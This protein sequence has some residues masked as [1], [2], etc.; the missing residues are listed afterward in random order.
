[1]NRRL[2]CRS[3]WAK[4]VAPI[5][6]AAALP[7]LVL[8]GDSY[9]LQSQCQKGDLRR[10]TAKIQVDGIL[11][12]SMDPKV[13]SLPLKVRGR[14]AYDELRLDAP[15]DGPSRRSLRYYREAQ[16]A[17]R[18]DKQTSGSTLRDDVR[19]ITARAESKGKVAISSPR[20]PLTREELELI[21]LQFGSLIAD[22][23]LPQSKVKIGD[24]WKIPNEALAGLSGL[25]AVSHGNIE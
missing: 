25:D 1:M 17:I 3:N 24:S 20:G 18:I 12:P 14:F 15:G 11:K 4:I 2:L 5:L 9:S 6:F 22:R 7:K 13:P 10:V 23:L 16:A 19:L 8:A 21:D